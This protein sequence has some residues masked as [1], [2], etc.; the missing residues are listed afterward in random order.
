MEVKMKK[1]LPYYLSLNYPITVETYTE[2]EEVHYSLEIPD[3]PG[4]GAAAKTFNEAEEKLQDAKE[5]W[6]S[7]SLKRKLPIPEPVSED[8][9]SG[10]F[11]LRMPTKLHMA[12]AKQ[13]KREKLSLNQ[14][15]K[16]V[17]EIHTTLAYE[18]SL[19]AIKLSELKGTVIDRSSLE[20]TLTDTSGSSVTVG[21]SVNAGTSPLF[22]SH[23]T[24]EGNWLQAA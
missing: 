2:D 23:K 16:S 15:V 22:P 17:L 9:F 24:E 5:L 8:D 1:T 11:L 18:K 7:A 3:L 19:Q 12:L 20:G 10:K 21:A 6:I 4:C 14:Y 13:A